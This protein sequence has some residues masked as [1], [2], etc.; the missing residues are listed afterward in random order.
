MPDQMAHGQRRI[1]WCSV[2]SMLFWAGLNDRTISLFVLRLHPAVTDSTLAFFFAIGPVT[3]VLTALMSP[4][5][6]LKGKKRVMVPFYFISAVFLVFL[7]LLPWLRTGWRPGPMVAATGACLSGYYILRS[8][9]F[10]GWFPLINDNVPDESR[11][12][13]FGR[14]RT[15][16]QLMLILCSLAVGWFLG[17]QPGLGR[18]QAIFVVAL[19]ANVA[20]TIGILAIPEAPV[21]PPA[22]PTTFWGRLAIPFR[23]PVFVNFLIFGIVFNLAAALAG[24]FA[25][26]CMKSTLGAGDN[27]VVWMDT[28]ASVGAAA[29]LPL[30]GRFVDR[31][32]G[33]VLF[34]IL[35]PP[36]A[37]VNLFWLVLAP[38]H[39]SWR[40]L[41][42]AYSVL[43]GIL[44]FGVGVGVT[45]MMIGS[46]RKGHESAYINICLVTNTL[47][48]GVA[49]FLGTLIARTLTEVR[50]TWGPF[51]L[52]SNRWVFLARALLM[53]LPLL[54]L[55]KLSRRHGGH[56]GE[57]LQ[58]FSTGLAGFFP[59]LWREQRRG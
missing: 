54:I 58:R 35:L 25:V 8:L 38:E 49:P 3:A 36:L 26:R 27:F 24:P 7:T 52:D 32:G 37:L 44:I 33:R 18:F 29:T 28:L 21:V 20:M 19:A 46:A 31:F 22:G 45:D 40:Y 13:F 57:A 11:G 12:R 17:H 15:S 16:W 23:N 5:V 42:A 47:A 34:A 43:Q 4:L 59:G 41:L 14:L 48:A 39:G 51:V 1:I 6:D 56:V 2:T 30:W 9:G 55:N 10:A 50:I 53:L